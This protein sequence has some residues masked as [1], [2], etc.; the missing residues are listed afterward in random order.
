MSRSDVSFIRD[1]DTARKYSLN[2]ESLWRSTL[3]INYWTT[4]VFISSVRRLSFILT[5]KAW[6]LV[7]TV[8]FVWFASPRWYMRSASLVFHSSETPWW[9][10]LPVI[11]GDAKLLSKAPKSCL[12]THFN[13]MIIHPIIMIKYFLK[14]SISTDNLIR[15]YTYRWK[16]SLMW[17]SI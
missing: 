15:F 12:N 17:I 3:K 14:T 2:F 10:P 8:T 5:W 11:P 4:F 1:W 9:G 13:H 7:W 6:V 16:W